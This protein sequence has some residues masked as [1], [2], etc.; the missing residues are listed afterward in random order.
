MRNGARNQT[1]TSACASIRCTPLHI[2]NQPWSDGWCDPQAHHGR[3]E[4]VIPPE[5]ALKGR[6]YN[7]DRLQIRVLHCSW[8]FWHAPR[9][10]SAQKRIAVPPCPVN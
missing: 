2:Y 9:G 6:C 4:N 10:A 3:R 5:K 1:P 8:S 7:K